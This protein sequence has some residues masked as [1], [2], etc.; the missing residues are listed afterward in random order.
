MHK[1]IQLTNPQADQIPK[2]IEKNF[3][4]F[5]PRH[6][7]NQPDCPLH[8]FAA[9]NQHTGLA[10]LHGILYERNGW[11]ISPSAASF[12]GIEFRDNLPTKVLT[13]FIQAMIS[14]CRA[15]SLKGI[16]LLSYPFCYVPKNAQLLHEALLASGYCV[17]YDDLNYHLPVTSQPL[18]KSLSSFKRNT[19]RKSKRAGFHGAIWQQPDI[20]QLFEFIRQARERRGIPLTISEEKLGSLIQDFPDVC[21]VFAVWQQDR[22]A[23]T[24]VGIRVAPGILYHFMG[25]DHGDFLAYSPTV[26][27]VETLY[28]YCQENNITLLDLGTASSYGVRNEGLAF[29]K[30]LLGGLESPKYAYELAF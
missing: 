12:G 13:D 4:F 30:R 16:R 5:Q 22:L 10:E 3:L 21:H 18:L 14:F 15:N 9:V 8:Y 25:A 1:I 11:A 19:L 20:H 2:F 29:F 26:L 28:N 27:L 7:L 23:A 6:F 24:S 17:S